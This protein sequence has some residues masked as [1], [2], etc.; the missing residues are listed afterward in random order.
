M[1]AMLSNLITAWLVLTILSI[2]LSVSAGELLGAARRYGLLL[3]AMVANILL[4]PAL[5]VG[6]Y[7]LFELPVEIGT[8]ML[9]CAATPGSPLGIKLTQLAKG[10]VP[11]AV[12]LGVMLIGV[13]VATTPVVASLILPAGD[14]VRLSFLEIMQL[15]VPHVLLP[16]GV[17]VGI[18]SLKPRWAEPLLHPLQ[19]LSNGLFA[20]LVVW[21]LVQDFDTLAALGLA[22]AGAMAIVGLGSWL[23]GYTL[24]G[25]DRGGRLALAF[26]TSFRN[27]ALALLIAASMR[28]HLVITG[29]VAY[30]VLALVVN[31]LAA[32]YARRNI[33]SVRLKANSS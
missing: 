5:A 15:L 23:I 29:A 14:H 7:Y 27:S 9:V 24:A 25:T 17:A 21:V 30:V 22:T 2:G 26:G 6:L 32:W 13:S 31:L 10:D 20:I 1:I 18:K 11:V 33:E 8:G 3:R 19:L 12:G 16:L 28:Q 4:V